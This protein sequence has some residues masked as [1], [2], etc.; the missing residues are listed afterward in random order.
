MRRR[1]FGGLARTDLWLALALACVCLAVPATALAANLA[2][3]GSDPAES[4]R[5]N[6]PD[7]SHFDECEVDDA[8][9]D[10]ECTSYFQEQWQAFGFRPDSALEAP[11]ALPT[12]YKPAPPD[13]DP[14]PQLDAQGQAANLLAEDDNPAFACAMISGVRADSAWKFDTGNPDTTIAI[15]DTGIQLAGHRAEEQG[16]P[17][18]GRAADPAL[19]SWRLAARGRRLRADGA[20]LGQLRRGRQRRIQRPR[21]PAAT[22]GSTSPTARTPLTSTPPARRMPRPCSSPPT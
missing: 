20:Q 8:D 2:F 1:G 12:T 16:R 18:P 11:P 3:P 17:Q 21:L 15:L 7:D 5:A 9:D 6:T 4:P 19:G 22:R 13:L 10:Q 14:C